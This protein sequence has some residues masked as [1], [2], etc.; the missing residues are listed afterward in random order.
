MRVRVNDPHGGRAVAEGTVSVDGRRPV[1]S[2][3]RAAAKVLG[4]RHKRGGGKAGA[5]RKPPPTSTSLRF[6]LSE[7]AMVTV[8]VRR[9][10]A[11]RRAEGACSTRSKRGRPC[12]AWSVARQIRRAERA[13][14]NRL[15]LRS[16]GLRRGRYRIVL[17]ATDAVGNRSQQRT[18]GLRVVRLPR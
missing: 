16:R 18:I 17:S 7:A 6:R 3:V 8:S 4:L 13:G 2:D 10:R 15:T 9:A 14:R 1:V 12:T 11:G 5:K